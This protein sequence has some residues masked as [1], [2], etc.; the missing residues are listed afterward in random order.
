MN[1]NATWKVSLESYYPYL[2]PQEVSKAPTTL[3]TYDGLPKT[4]K[5]RFGCHCFL[6][7]NP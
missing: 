4:L 7:V 3:G 2:L 1:Q 5:S 6:G